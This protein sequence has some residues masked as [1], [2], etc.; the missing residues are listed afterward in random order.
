MPNHSLR[1][2][3]ALI[4]GLALFTSALPAQTTNGDRTGL[5]APSIQEQIDTL[6]AGQERILRELAEIKRLLAET[7]VRSEVGV[8]PT[9]PP[10]MTLNITGEP[11]KGDA[12]AKVAILE[13]SDFECSYCGKYARENFPRIEADYIKTGKIR[14]LYRDLPA[15]E[16]ANALAAAQAA[17]CAGEQGKF[18]EMHDILFA[19]QPALAPSDL[20]SYAQALGLDPKT[21]KDCLE[22]KKY[23][24]AIRRSAAGVERLG[25]YGTPAF[26]IGTLSEDGNVL[27]ATKTLVGGDSLER[28]KSALE[29]VLRSS[30][31]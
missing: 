4:F 10:V 17:R 9:M 6:K 5:P 24:E 11:F 31:K 18:W 7:P 2:I 12:K 26:L 28:V 3:P 23:A 1:K 8:R 30:A 15:R 25:V 21:F 19:A 13:Y 27:R 29:E 22:S 20:Q 14:Y 16:H